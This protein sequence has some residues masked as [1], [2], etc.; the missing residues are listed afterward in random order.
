MT[1]KR[2]LTVRVLA[3]EILFFGQRVTLACDGNCNKAWGMST[4][5]RVDLDE[6]NPDDFYWLADGELGDAPQ[7]PGTYEGTQGKPELDQRLESK[8]CARECER[9][10]IFAPHETVALPDFSA[11]LYNIKSHAPEAQKVAAKRDCGD[12]ASFATKEES[13]YGR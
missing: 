3:K 12:V 11:H 2:A 8:W 7:D 13:D 6:E 10:R 4:R 5:P 9:S 1:T